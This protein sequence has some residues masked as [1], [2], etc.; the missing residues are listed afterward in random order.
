LS[1]QSDLPAF[2][3]PPESQLKNQPSHSSQPNNSGS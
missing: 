3:S 1:N 2:F